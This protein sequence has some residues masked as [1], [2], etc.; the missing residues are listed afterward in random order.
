M[1]ESRCVHIAYTAGIN[2]FFFYNLSFDAII[3]GLRHLSKK[4]RQSILIATGAETRD[5]GGLQKYFDAVCRRLDVDTIDIFL[6]EYASPEENVETVLNDAL[7]I[8][9]QWKAYGD[10]VYGTGADAFETRWP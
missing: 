10:L 2:T 7:D 3:S 9:H 5:P 8:L 6:A 1:A 4:H